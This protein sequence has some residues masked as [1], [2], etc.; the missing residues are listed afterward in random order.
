[1]EIYNIEDEVEVAAHAGTDQKGTT[2]IDHRIG[3]KKIPD[4]ETTGIETETEAKTGLRTGT[5]VGILDEIKVAIEMG[6][7]PA[8]TTTNTGDE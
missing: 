8:K 7:M 1:M 2:A 5:V 3:S 6:I 4:L